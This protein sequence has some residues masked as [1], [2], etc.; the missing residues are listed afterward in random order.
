MWQDCEKSNAAG[1]QRMR[2]LVKQLFAAIGYYTGLLALCDL[3]VEKFA[4]GQNHVLLMY[5]RVIDDPFAEHEYAQTGT[6]VS[7]RAF[8]A[9]I[10]YISLKFKIL[11]AGDYIESLREGRPLPKQC[12]VVTFDDGW[13]DNYENAYPILKSYRVP[14]T[15]FVCTGFLNTTKK[16][17]FHEILHSIK[18]QGLSSEQLARALMRFLPDKSI[19]SDVR[20]LLADAQP[21]DVVID[22][23]FH[24]VKSLGANQLEELSSEL[25]K[26]S[27]KSDTAWEQRRFMMTWDE[28]RSLDMQIVEIG[29]HGQSH[30]LLTSIPQVDAKREIHESKAEIE[31]NLGTNVRTFAYPNGT[32]D[33]N[34]KRMVLEAGYLG[35][36]AVGGGDGSS[37][38]FTISRIGVHEGATTG[39]GEE[40]SKA[41][42]AW[43]LSATKRAMQRSRQDSSRT[44]Y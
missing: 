13:L 16:L 21:R 38:L 26:L 7:K 30:R 4:R 12:A 23:F 29:S 42:W 5:H 28:I 41:M 27:G 44:G 37:D 18:W 3:C 14:A 35:A 10:R 22:N 1:L 31:S 33:E 15:I 20:S 39:C 36:F 43:T 19:E 8:E 6:A 40:F 32:Y 25:M 24:L 34:I 9:Q 11:T 17:W 2:R